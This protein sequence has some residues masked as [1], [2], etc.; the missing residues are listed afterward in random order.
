MPRAVVTAKI[1]LAERNDGTE[2]EGLV[3]SEHLREISFGIR[4]GY[5]RG[6]SL[7]EARRLRAMERGVP[8]EEIEDSTESPREVL[9][10]QRKFVATLVADL[11]SDMEEIVEDR[12]VFCMAHGGYIH[13]FLSNIC[14]MNKDQ[15]EKIKNCAIS[16]VRV[17]YNSVDDYVCEAVEGL[18]N[19]TPAEYA[20]LHGGHTP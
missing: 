8:P 14:G 18:V 20:A 19:L 12:P 5:P 17:R 7:K 11:M 6:T 2:E 1:A 13:R 15:L 10:R 16:V 9:E 4:E 3:V